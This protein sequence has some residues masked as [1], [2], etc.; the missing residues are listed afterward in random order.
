MKQYWAVKSIGYKN[1]IREFEMR[2]KA[3]GKL[4]LIK[5]NK[6]GKEI[7]MRKDLA[8]EGI[9]E[10]AYSWGYY[11]KKDGEIHSFDLCEECYDDI[12][13]SFIIPVDVEKKA[14]LM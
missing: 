6:C 3:N 8:L 10:I 12:C 2:K 13:G 14:E 5:C 11:S 4:K 1:D 9:F 7:V